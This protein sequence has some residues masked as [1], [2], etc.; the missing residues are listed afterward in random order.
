M[1]EYLDA[2]VHQGH[3]WYRYNLWCN[4]QLLDEVWGAEP[5]VYSNVVDLYVHYLR[6][7]FSSAG[8]ED[9]IKTVRGVGY[10]LEEIRDGK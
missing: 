3:D 5:D 6:D 4:E 10:R 1:M 9:L 7:K 2:L 8:Y